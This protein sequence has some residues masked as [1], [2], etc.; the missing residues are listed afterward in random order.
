MPVIS[1]LL[2]KLFWPTIAFFGLAIL[3]F[4]IAFFA[5]IERS[6]TGSYYN[7]GS[8]KTIAVMAAII[9][10][11]V[12]MRQQGNTQA[13]HL[14]LYAPAALIL[15]SVLLFFLLAYMLGK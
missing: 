7:T 5:T 12:Y 15:V 1:T 6:A 14:I 8:L 9:I 13:A 4:A 11:A 2:S 10:G 3:V